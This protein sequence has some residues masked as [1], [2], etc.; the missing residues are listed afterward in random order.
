MLLPEMK[1]GPWSISARSAADGFCES[2]FFTGNGYLGMRGFAPWLPK[3]QPSA[4]AI[5]KA[6]LFSHISPHITDMVQ[7]P[8]VTMLIPDTGAPEA[9]EQ[10]L[11]LRSGVVS[12]SWET[13]ALSF[14]MEKTASMADSQLLL[15]RLT[16]K[17]KEKTSLSLRSIADARVRN[18]PVHDDQMIVSDNLVRLLETDSLSHDELLMHTLAEGTKISFSWQ[19]ISSRACLRRSSFEG[20]TAV[21]EL[22]AALEA[23]ESWTVEK[24]V[25]ILEGG[26]AAHADCTDPWES[27][28]LAWE[29]LW[30]DCDLEVDSDDVELQGAVRYNIFQLLCSNAPD[31]PDVSIGARGLTHGRYKGNTFWDTEIFMLPFFMW[32][33]PGAAKN[34]LLYRASR[35]GAAQALAKKQNLAGARFPW[36]C[37]TDGTEQCESWDIGLCEVHITADIA[38]AMGRYVEVTQDESFL[39]GQ[40]EAVWKETARYWPSRLS[41][42]EDRGLYSSFFVKGPD[43]Y[44]GAAVNNTYTNWMARHN[45]ALALAHCRMDEAEREKLRF[46]KDHITL[47]YDKSRSLYLQDELFERLEP[48]AFSKTGD[49][50]SYKALCFDR[51]QRYRAIKQADLVLLMCLFPEGFSDAEKRQVFL[52]YEPLT[53]HDSTLSWGIHALLALRL[54]LWEKAAAYLHKAVFLDLKDLMVSTGQEGLHLAGMGAAWQA[55]VYGAAGLWADEKGI[56]LSPMLPPGIRRLRFKVYYRG[57]KYAADIGRDGHTLQKEDA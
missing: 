2:V 49:T 53:L 39:E 19:L 51:L 8:D 4:H 37:S 50:P 34:L 10:R 28:R 54:G 43:E 57:E 23:G 16:V 30:E 21:T 52:T 26:E 33:R 40:A 24:R 13:T 48:S 44:C 35:L 7:L 55:L 25:R 11:D 5:F 1:I 38:Y 47:L 3:T 45:I 41:W 29:K 20:E 36:M 18:L 32:T 22:A 15:V 6:G 46:L 12:F 31:R 56:M 27:S 17:A 42:E 9:V 14:R